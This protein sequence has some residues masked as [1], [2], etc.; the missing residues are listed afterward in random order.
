MLLICALA[1]LAQSEAQSPA[2]EPAPTEISGRYEGFGRSASRGDIP[3]V[4]EIRGGAE[5]ITGVM[6]TP[7]GDIAITGGSYGDGVLKLSFETNGERGT[8][9]A[10]AHGATLAGEFVGFGDRGTVE[11]TR[12]GDAP[13]T[14]DTRPVLTLGAHAWAEDLEF[15]AR[16]IP[17]RHKN[18][19]H[20]VSARAFRAAVEVLRKRLPS[21]DSGQVVVEMSRIASLVGDGHTRVNWHWVYPR[22][23][24]SLFWFGEELRVTGSTS[25]HQ[26]VV[27]ARVVKIGDVSA[28]EAHRRALRYIPRGENRWFELAASAD[29]LTYP[30]FLHALGL[31]TNAGRAAYTLRTDTGETFSVEL[32]AR[33]ENGGPSEWVDAAARTPLARQRPDEP[34]WFTHLEPSRTVY[35]NFRGYPSS[36]RF[37]ELAAELGRVLDERSVARLVVDM[38]QNGGGDFTRGRRY[39]VPLIRQRPRLMQRGRLWVV[40]GRWTYSAGMTN[41]ADLSNEAGALLIGEPT[42]GRPNNY[43]EGREF[44]LPN[45][46]LRVWVSTEYYRF[47]RRAAAALMPDRWVEPRWADYKAGRDAVLEWLTKPAATGSRGRGGVEPGP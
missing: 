42:G 16:E 23:P 7:F 46:R 33:D 8:L 18:A 19:F 10:R 39:L 47:G 5:T 38:R 35:V 9:T 22:V 11:L 30:V 28:T 6:R 13:P 12:T 2:R 27:G 40:T 20:R 44:L 3:L 15:L 31:S 17:R 26:K 21:L 34:F 25:P 24:L 45:S 29:S 32:E 4:V 41:A 1:A 43:Q 36:E 37:A 14:E